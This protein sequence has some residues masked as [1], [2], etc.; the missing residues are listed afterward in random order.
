MADPLLSVA[1]RRDL[2]SLG[3]TRLFSSP[4]G[5]VA[6]MKRIA[7]I[8][9]VPPWRGGVAHHTDQLVKSIEASHQVLAISFA[10]MYPSWLYPGQAISIP[11]ERCDRGGN[12]QFI[13]RG[14]APR[15]WRKAVEVIS[16]FQPDAIVLPWWTVFWA[17]LCLYV[18]R[19]LERRGF[20]VL[21]ICHNVVDHDA[22]RWKRWVARLALARG[23]GFLTHTEQNRRQLIELLPSAR[24]TVYPHPLYGHLPVAGQVPQRRAALELLFFGYVR[25]YK[26]V[27][28]LIEALGLLPEVDF[29][30]CIAGEFWIDR[31]ILERKTKR[32]GIS[33]R[34]TMIPHY[35]ADE[36]A[37]GLMSTADAVV[38]PY[39]QAS[40]SG[41]AALALHYDTPVVAT[42]VGG[43]AETVIDGETGYLVDPGNSQLLAAGIK[44]LLS[45]KD[46]ASSIAPHKE[47]ASWAGMAAAVAQ[48]VTAMAGPDVPVGSRSGA[49]RRRPG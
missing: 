9:P 30:L 3:E 44:R 38:L 21:Y 33:D 7:L 2:R 1:Y 20:P 15:T 25:P 35:V 14:D 36:E 4:V 43:L 5:V 23:A 46:W 12:L 10:S 32:L 37:A 45:A 34:V 28:L 48:V 18:S 8:G 6:N 39:R 24:V 26:G 29:H 47:T 49:I 31:A 41:V 27:D 13:L 11:L 17:P 42:R 16:D 22:H 40:G 19:A